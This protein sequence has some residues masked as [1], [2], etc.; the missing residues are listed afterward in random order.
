MDLSGGSVALG[1]DITLTCAVTGAI[2]ADLV[3]WTKDGELMFND[4]RFI[5]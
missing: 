5:L 1:D 4:K 3:F 2:K